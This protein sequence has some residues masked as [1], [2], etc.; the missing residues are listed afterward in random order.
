VWEEQYSK[1]NGI[2]IPEAVKLL[3]NSMV[4][5]VPAF[6]LSLNELMAFPWIRNFPVNEASA[7]DEMNSIWQ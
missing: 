5:S 1:P 2:L 4:S 3:F 7:K 6:R